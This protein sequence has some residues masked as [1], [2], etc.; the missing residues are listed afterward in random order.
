MFGKQ[1]YRPSNLPN[2]FRNIHARLIFFVVDVC[3]NREE[4]EL[5]LFLP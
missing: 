2:E 4:S 1:G 3:E 5:L